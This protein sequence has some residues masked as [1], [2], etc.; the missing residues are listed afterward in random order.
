MIAEESSTEVLETW[1]L[2]SDATSLVESCEYKI[3]RLIE[4]QQR[5]N[6]RIAEMRIN[7]LKEISGLWELAYK[8]EK[9]PTDYEYI[10]VKYFSGLEV[11]DESTKQL[12]NFR[13]EEITKIYNDKIGQLHKKNNVLGKQ[14]QLFEMMG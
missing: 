12:L 13:I 7:Y 6:D 8:N 5:Q 14:I 2:A 10:P 4:K 11:S 3:L 9:F 1:K